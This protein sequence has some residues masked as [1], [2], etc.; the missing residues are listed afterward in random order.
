MSPTL[1]VA[2]VDTGAGVDT[3]ADTEAGV[4]VTGLPVTAVVA[5]R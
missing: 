4:E 2:G 3:E 1:A 5:P